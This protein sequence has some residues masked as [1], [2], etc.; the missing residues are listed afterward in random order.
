MMVTVPA[1]VSGC[2]LRDHVTA[3]AVGKKRHLPARSPLSSI[4]QKSTP[5][6]EC[7][8]VLPTPVRSTCGSRRPWCLNNREYG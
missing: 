7:R 3:S 4:S 8:Y 1:S 5:G 6:E 2:A